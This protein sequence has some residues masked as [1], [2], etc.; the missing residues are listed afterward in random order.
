MSKWLKT[1]TLSLVMI[2]MIPLTFFGG[3]LTE[4]EKGGAKAAALPQWTQYDRPEQFGVMTDEDVFI[5]MRDGTKLVANVYRPDAPGKYPVILTQT[6]YNKNSSLGAPN[7]YLVK[8]GYVHVVADVRGTGGSQG[9]W[10]SFG[11]AEQKDGYELVAWAAS[12]PWSDGSVG[13]WGASYMAIN[14]LLTAAQQPPALKA[15]FPIVPMADVYRDILMSGGMMNTGFIPTWLGLVTSSGLLP[16][17]YTLSEPL[18]ASTVLLGHAG[19]T[20]GFPINTLSTLLTGGDLAYDGKGWQTRS[21][22]FSADR[23][24]VPAFITGGLHDIFQRG[25]PLLYEK[26]KKNVNAKLLMGNWTHGDYGSGLPHDGV[27]PLDQIALRWFDHYLKGMNTRVD[28]IPKVTQ[29]VLGDGH[30]KVQADYPQPGARASKW[31]LNRQGKL[32]EEKPSST[33]PGDLMPQH[34]V[35]GICSGSTNQ[36]LAGAMDALPCKKDNRLTELTEVTYTSKPFETDFHI[37]GPI[38][39]ELFISTTAK[40]A[41]VSVRV[42]DVA[43]DG[44]STELTAGWLAASFRKLDKSK[45]RYLDGEI[46]QPWHPFTAESVEEVVPGMPMKLNIEIFPTNAVIKKGHKL[47]V[48]V[49]P[50]DFPHAISPLPQLGKQAG[51]TV[52]IL[53]DANHPSSI[54]V[55]ALP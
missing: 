30:F 6:P 18:T 41:V 16:P 11:E 54:V 15:I 23:I 31:Y 32:S 51:G 8:R 20:T 55:P 49:G 35:N 53:H 43:P 46:I 14:Q 34:P 3:I 28:K 45:T 10:D 42:T 27:P 19:A 25:E 36:W 26:L 37:S 17:T 38:G 12:Q 22:Y 47:R 33:E 39:A 52:T 48:A 24:R 5:T 1:F 7:E 44:T 13:L 9:S 29:Y 21:P 4:G 40:E 50:S 2:L